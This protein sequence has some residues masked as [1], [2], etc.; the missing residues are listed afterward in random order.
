VK[1]IK[2]VASLLIVSVSL[3][4]NPITANAESLLWESPLSGVSTAPLDIPKSATLR[5]LGTSIYQSNPDELIFKIVMAGSLEE[6]PF[7]SSSRDL[8]VWIYWPFT[9]CWSADKNNCAG[10][11][12]LSAP[13]YSSI[14]PTTK[15]TQHIFAM[16]HD[17]AS[18]INVKATSCKIPW[19]IS[20]SYYERDTVN[21]AVS[22]T[23]LGIPKDFG[24]YGYSGIT[25]NG[26]KIN[27]F[28]DFQ[29]T[30]NP[31]HNLAAGYANQVELDINQP[32]ICV[33]GAVG[34][35]TSK[36]TLEEQCTENSSWEFSYCN[37]SPLADLQVY[38]SKTWRKI[39]TVKGIKDDTT[40][41]DLSR[42]YIFNFTN[43]SLTEKF[44]IKNYGNKKFKDS[45]MNL[46]IKQGNK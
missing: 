31:F 7:Q 35:G 16:S 17:K 3:I 46:N 34:T 38:R 41:E 39:Q 9:G 18:N 20:N 22:I 21:F 5:G 45:Y 40:C 29:T 14:Y 37:S 42:P 43:S 33:S 2:N 8:T 24:F 32:L 27:S 11:F 26:S 23:C 4:L 28:T 1:K 15:S 25:S 19:W 44:R 12:T 36:V 6:K 13:T 30:T 10:L